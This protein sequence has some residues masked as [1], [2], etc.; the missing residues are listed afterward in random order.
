[1][2]VIND[3]EAASRNA[4]SMETVG[5]FAFLN[6]VCISEFYV[7]AFVNLLCFLNFVCAFVN[8]VRIY[9]VCINESCVC[10]YLY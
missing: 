8:F 2:I 7:H 5:L 4:K 9:A 3:K 1:L 6:C 10:M